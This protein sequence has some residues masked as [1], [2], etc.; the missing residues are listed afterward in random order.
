MAENVKIGVQAELDKQDL[1]R[2]IQE[3]TQQMNR[4]GSTIAQ[5]NKM[6]FNPVDKAGLEDL[7]KVVQQFEQLKKINPDLRRRLNATGQGSAGFNDVD[8][9]RIYTGGSGAQRV[10]G[11]ATSGTA[12][13]GRLTATPATPPGGGGGGGGGGGSGGGGGTGTGGGYYP[14][15]GIVNSGLGA[16]GP[17]GG[18]AARSINAGVSGGLGAGVGA[19][20]G[21]LAAWGVGKAVGTV[22]DKKDAAEREFIGYDTL[23]RQ[24][25]DLGVSFNALKTSVREASKAMDVGFDTGQQLAGQFVRTSGSG[26]R[27]L[28]LYSE[29]T[30]GIGLSRSFGL[31]PSAGVGALATMRAMKVTSNSD[32]SKKF[33][34]MIGEAVA[35]GGAFSKADELLQA[36]SNFTVQQTRMGMG[37]AN[38]SGYAGMLAGA[39]R[40]GIPG[41]DMGGAT[42]LLGGVNSAIAAGGRSG[43]ASK[44]FMM[45]SLGRRLGLNPVQT[46]L[47]QEQGAFGTGAGTFGDGS[48]YKMFSE[49]YGAKMPGGKAAGSTQTNLSMIMSDIVKRYGK[50]PDLML[51][52]ISGMFGT[53]TSQSMALSMIAPEKMGGMQARLARLGIS[54]ND[55]KASGINA[56]GQLEASGM[57]EEQKDAK[58][59]EIAKKEQESTPGSEARRTREGID[60]IA[61]QMASHLVPL[62][63]SIRDGVL[64]L[65]GGGKSS[66]SAVMKQIADA[67]YHEKADPLLKEKAEIQKQ[68]GGGGAL[69]P[70]GP[71]FHS[72]P[73]EQQ[74][75]VLRKRA[76]LE[77]RLAEVN[78]QLGEVTGQRDLAAGGYIQSAPSDVDDGSA[79]AGDGLSEGG[80]VFDKNNLGQDPWLRAELIKTDKMLG[81]PEGT[82]AAQ[83]QKES[84]YRPGAVSKAGARGLLQI[85]PGTLASMNRRFGREMNPSD[86]RDAVLMHRELM[87]ENV[88]KFG[89]EGALEAYN[90][91]W[92]PS[93][94]NNAETRD[95]KKWITSHAS[96][97]SGQ[98]VNPGRGGGE[99][100]AHLKVD[101]N[102]DGKKAATQNM[103]AKIQ[104]PTPSGK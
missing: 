39:L 96:E 38:V 62:T 24:L 40:T 101:V 51:N 12:F 67:E 58:A 97:F 8:W 21:G 48:V 89:T 47:L 71:V 25:G 66:P 61:Q 55:V 49:R 95:Y 92:N 22:M 20:L 19:L 87:R 78:K 43:E 91:G 93:K 90:G 81:L 59:R 64:Y 46:M 72:L 10:F 57:S 45:A 84:R 17:V 36:V 100:Y 76:N 102:V 5:A 83:F 37:A 65:A 69:R 63:S 88:A 42:N 56:L 18:I 23:K 27:G 85:M 31:D 41:M 32:D 30:T 53:N 80:K 28:N 7:K 29:L 1:S 14:G 52:A 33:A 60:N 99:A 9:S 6:K 34:L 44:N 13:G 35:K 79:D 50:S 103:V 70:S 11:Y 94:W 54:M 26:R 4:L 86:P 73:K 2:T 75:A 74:E 15:Q 16:A 77:K 98:I 3:F 104:P 82:S 68:L